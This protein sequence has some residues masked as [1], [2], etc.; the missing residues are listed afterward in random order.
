[1]KLLEIYKMFYDVIGTLLLMHECV[2]VINVLV[3]YR[4]NTEFI[5]GRLICYFIF[6]NF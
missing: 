3:C 5:Q 6:I 4:I 1:M 2:S